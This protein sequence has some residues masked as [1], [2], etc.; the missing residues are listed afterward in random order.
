ME[1]R[2]KLHAKLKSILGSDHV[3]F[4]PPETIHLE[5]PCI[6]YHVESAAIKRA[7]DICYKVSARYGLLIIDRN[8]D[9]D[10]P[11]RLLSLPMCSP[12]TVYTAD[13]LYH[14]PFTLY[15]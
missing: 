14:Y 2:L 11:S 6:I 5:Y 4:Q 7:D 8:P 3:Y 1:S 12:G 10:I 15:F 9:S 13:N